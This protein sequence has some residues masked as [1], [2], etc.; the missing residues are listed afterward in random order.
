MHA[1][2]ARR[3]NPQRCNT[4]NLA[5]QRN[6]KNRDFVRSLMERLLAV[7]VH[8]PTSCTQAHKYRPKPENISSIQKSDLKRKPGAKYY[9]LQTN[10]NS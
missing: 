2:F 9:G 5:Q 3:D 1:K 7:D 4:E 6:H 10:M 8:R